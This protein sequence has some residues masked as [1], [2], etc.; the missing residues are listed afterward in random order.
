MRRRSGP[1][2]RAAEADLSLL[3]LEIVLSVAFSASQNWLALL[4]NLTLLRFTTRLILLYP[5]IL[6]TPSGNKIFCSGPST[7][8]A[9]RGKKANLHG[10][11]YTSACIFTLLLRSI[12]LTIS[13]AWPHVV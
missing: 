13:G 4:M 9:F 7:I 11:I 10:S 5:Q 3:V 12:L 2:H 1:K 6:A 8:A